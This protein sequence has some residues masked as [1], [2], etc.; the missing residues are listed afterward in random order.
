MVRA[1]CVAMGLGILLLGSGCVAVSAKNNK[2][3]CDRH[4]VV[5]ND[6]V[7]VVDTA[8]G[9]AYTVDVSTAGPLPCCPKKCTHEHDAD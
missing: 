1:L 7:Y 3:I 2:L 4:A 5:V 8:S 6:Q 9:K